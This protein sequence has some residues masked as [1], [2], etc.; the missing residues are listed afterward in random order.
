[1]SKD[2]RVARELLLRFRMWLPRISELLLKYV[3]EEA[4]KNI[5]EQAKKEYE[6]LVQSIPEVDERAPFWD[7][8]NFYSSWIAVNRAVKPYGVTVEQV[9]EMILE[10]SFIKFNMREEKERQETKRSW[11]EDQEAVY[12]EKAVYSEEKKFADDWIYSFVKGDGKEFDFGLDFTSCAIYN[13]FKAQGEEELMP[14][15]CKVDY[16]W[17]DSNQLGL[18]RN[19]TIAQG[20]KCCDLRWKK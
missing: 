4:V 15:I 14:Y 6:A 11:F 3:D 10:E 8:I 19:Y 16:V 7:E 2:K 5:N 1:M 20:D 12:R 18:K 13:F 9:G 17:S